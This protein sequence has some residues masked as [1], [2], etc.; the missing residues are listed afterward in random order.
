MQGHVELEHKVTG[1]V[2]EIGITLGST[3][4]AHA[5][6]WIASDSPAKV[7]P[8]TTLCV[9]T[10]S[11]EATVPVAVTVTNVQVFALRTALAS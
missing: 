4:H 8:C 5:A 9:D 1:A 3:S 10:A 6:V 11:V 2:P 7:A